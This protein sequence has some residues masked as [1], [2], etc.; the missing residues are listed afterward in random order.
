MNKTR[1]ETISDLGYDDHLEEFVY[2]YQTFKDE[3]NIHQYRDMMFRCICQNDQQKTAI[4]M[5]NNI[6]DIN[7]HAGKEYAFR[8]SCL[9]GNLNMVKWLWNISN[10]SIQIDIKDGEAYL[11]AIS[12]KNYDLIVWLFSLNHTNIIY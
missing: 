11:N 6:P 7:I 8:M 12:S 10:G 9:K 4:W 1:Y 2:M 5:I 3:I